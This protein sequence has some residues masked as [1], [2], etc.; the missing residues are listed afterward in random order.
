MVNIYTYNGEIFRITLKKNKKKIKDQQY[1]EHFKMRKH[2]GYQFD[3]VAGFNL[4]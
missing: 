3:V 4:S 1:I 2:L